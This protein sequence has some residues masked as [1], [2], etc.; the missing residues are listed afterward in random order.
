MARCHTGRR[1]VTLVELLVAI[2][3]LSV[4]LT[5]TTLSL[6]GQKRSDTDPVSIAV[7]L[8][9]LR[10]AAITSGIARTSILKDSTNTILVTALPDGRVIS[11]ILKV[12]RL[13]GAAIHNDAK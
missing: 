11:D 3:V 7:Q 5:I 13:D 9:G 8:R 12:N 10:T 4:V 1:G 2:A 6:A